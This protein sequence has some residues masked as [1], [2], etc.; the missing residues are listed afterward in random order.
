MMMLLRQLCLGVGLCLA[1]G[2]AHG[3]S[4]TQTAQ[5]LNV[6]YA[7]TPAQCV[8]RTP[9]FACSGVLLRTVAP[10]HGAAFWV[11][12]ADESG[13]LR[14]EFLRK[15]RAGT[16]AQ[17]VVGYLLFDRLT[18]VGLGKP[19]QA[20]LGAAQ[21][22][23]SDW[24]A[25]LPAQLP[26]QGLF[27]DT[28]E[29]TGL[30]HAQRRQRD[31]F[32][33]TGLWL[34]ILRFQPDHAQGKV[35]GFARQ[36]QLDDGLRVARRLNARYQD[37]TMQCREDRPP[38]A[39]SGVFARTVGVGAFD[40]WNPSP[41]SITIQHVSFSYLRRDGNVSI[42]VSPQG[43]V[44]RELAAPVVAPFEHTCT[45][46]VD[47]GTHGVQ[48]GS[49][50]GCT[51][52]GVCS[53]MGLDSV[54]AWAT[55]Y[56]GVLYQSCSLGTDAATL[57]LMNDIR[58]Q[59]PGVTGWN[60]AMF[61]VWPQNIGKALGVE[62]VFYSNTTLYVGDGRPGARTFQRQYFN[63]T[64]TQLPLFKLDLQRPDGQVFSYDPQDQNL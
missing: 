51:F 32:Q 2:T 13:A 9:A 6:R 42:V 60:E 50:S 29:V 52:A 44:A 37:T 3:L 48:A 56:K 35:F 43:Y 10:A 17:P 63:K 7:N 39:C 14:F 22:L 53:Q 62:A 24:N 46:P 40:F 34:P 54:A 25:Q 4:G 33:A 16:L 19:Y 45:Y 57:A 15:D 23:V 58:R 21:V 30:L 55:R 49:R 27:Y 38:F 47:G 59:V 5:Q 11:P 8:A 26:I 28:R 36:D 61:K 64:A 1:L 20:S 12:A 41:Q 18:A 31:Y